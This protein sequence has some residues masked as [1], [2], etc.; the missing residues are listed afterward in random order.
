MPSSSRA[1]EKTEL[2]SLIYY[3]KYWCQKIGLAT[4][5]LFLS[6]K[7]V[8]WWKKMFF[9]LFDF[10]LINVHILH[11]KRN[12]QNI[13]IYLSGKSDRRASKCHQSG[14]HEA[15]TGKFCEKICGHRP[16]CIQ[17]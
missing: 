11:Q 7:S 5:I 8:K 3:N 4:L 9:H 12:K 6:K 1:H 16:F 13:R 2:L 15:V 14:S 10:V 17:E